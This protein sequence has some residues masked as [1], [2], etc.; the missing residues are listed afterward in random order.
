MRPE[1][2]ALLGSPLALTSATLAEHW[3]GLVVV[4][5]TGRMGKELRLRGSRTWTSVRSVAA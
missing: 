1:V 3:R 5:I 2:Q 4:R